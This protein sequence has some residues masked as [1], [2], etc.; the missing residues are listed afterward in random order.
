MV[1]SVTCSFIFSLFQMYNW[2][3]CHWN[4][5][6][7]IAESYHC[8]PFTFLKFFQ[9]R[10]FAVDWAFTLISFLQLVLFLFLVRK[11]TLWRG[12]EGIVS[13]WGG[14]RQNL[15]VSWWAVVGARNWNLQHS[16]AAAQQHTR[17]YCVGHDVQKLWNAGTRN[18]LFP[19]LGLMPLRPI[20][21]KR[22]FYALV[23][24]WGEVRL[25]FETHRSQYLSRVQLVLAFLPTHTISKHNCFR[26]SINPRASLLIV[27]SPC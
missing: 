18:G 24:S 17:L 1:L 2:R 3:V 27:S 4:R 10:D 5:C 20:V 6:L 11:R 19:A 25:N 13:W 21:N 7:C 14:R 9:L 26:V 12:L 15:L 23:S 8:V 22:L 16:H